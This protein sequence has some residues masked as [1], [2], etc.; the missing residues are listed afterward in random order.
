MR[1]GKSSA[2]NSPNPAQI[3]DRIKD[4]G[5]TD[6]E[7]ASIKEAT[8]RDPRWLLPAVA[9]GG[10]PV[11]VSH[12][13]RGVLRYLRVWIAAS[14]LRGTARETVLQQWPEALDR[15]VLQ[16]VLPK[17]HGNK[18]TL[19][20]SLRATAAFLAGGH[21]G[22]PGPSPLYARASTRPLRSPNRMRW[23]LV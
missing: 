10:F 8:A 5:F 6:A 16:K 9:A 22:S 7:I 11:R 19:G 12:S 23:R 21:K 2:T 3:L 20:D 18:R 13:E 17:I 4:L 14:M 15:A 1:T